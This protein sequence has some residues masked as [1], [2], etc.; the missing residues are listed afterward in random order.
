VLTEK[1]N[2]IHKNETPQLFSGRLLLGD[3]V[4]SVNQQK[5]PH[6]NL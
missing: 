4:N 3:F 5:P 2:E 6:Q 1:K